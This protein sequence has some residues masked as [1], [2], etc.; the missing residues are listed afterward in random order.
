[1]LRKSVNNDFQRGGQTMNISYR[2]LI[3]WAVAVI[4]VLCGPWSVSLAQ[5]QDKHQYIWEGPVPVKDFVRQNGVE[6]HY[7]KGGNNFQERG[8]VFLKVHNRYKVKVIVSYKFEI[9]DLHTGKTITHKQDDALTAL[10]VREDGGA[11]YNVPDSSD[12]YLGAKNW[13]PARFAVQNAEITRMSMALSSD[14]NGQTYEVYPNDELG[15]KIQKDADEAQRKQQEQQKELERKQQEERDR[16]QQELIKREQDAQRQ[17]EEHQRQY[18]AEQQKRYDQQLAQWK[19]QQD[20][21]RRRQDQRKQ[22]IMRDTDAKIASYKAAIDGVNAI[23][24]YLLAINDINHECSKE[25]IKLDILDLADGSKDSEVLR[26]ERDIKSSMKEEFEQ[27]K[28]A[29]LKQLDADHNRAL[30]EDARNKHYVNTFIQD[31]DSLE[32]QSREAYRKADSA[33]SETTD[34]MEKLSEAKLNAKEREQE[35]LLQ[36]EMDRNQRDWEAQEKARLERENP[37]LA[38]AL[39]AKAEQDAKDKAE[40]ERKAVEARMMAETERKQAEERVKQATILEGI[41]FDAGELAKSYVRQLQDSSSIDTFAKAG[42]KAILSN[43]YTV[44]VAAFSKYQES[45]PTDDS[46][47]PYRALSMVISGDINGGTKLLKQLRSSSNPQVVQNTSEIITKL[48]T[49]GVQITGNADAEKF[50]EEGRRNAAEGLW[51]TSADAYRKAIEVDPT[52]A[53]WHFGWAVALGKQ[54]KWAEAAA[55]YKASAK[56]NPTDAMTYANM[57]A[58]LLQVKQ[59]DDAVAAYLEAVRLEPSNAAY[60]DTL[61]TAYWYAGKLPDAI[62]CYIEAVRINPSDSKYQD[63]LNKA[64]EAQA[65]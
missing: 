4:L 43:D 15:K 60:N 19:S 26:L 2:N 50:A 18:K 14:P 42:V 41:K 5:A 56:L 13:D 63:H 64:K 12:R 23:A 40:R 36:A 32:R 11:F 44:A 62:K 1:M 39:R 54:K 46:Y 6:L 51:G 10:E 49:M 21:E 35:A 37:E 8:F 17:Y 3:F 58:C 52:E 27:N 38:A 34:L 7:R 9:L 28:E 16:K 57:G 55:A 61:G 47:E 48:Q 45:N 24:N 25:V 22:Q 20:A 65:K 53:K 30:Q 59:W 31:P 29:R 33:R